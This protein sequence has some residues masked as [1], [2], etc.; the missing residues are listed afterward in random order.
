MFN[1]SLVFQQLS[2]FTNETLGPSWQQLA[3]EMFLK[4][5]FEGLSDGLGSDIEILFN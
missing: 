3:Y 4:M 2:I 1:Q 5:V